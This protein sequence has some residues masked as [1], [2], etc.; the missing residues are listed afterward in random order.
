MTQFVPVEALVPLEVES[1]CNYAYLV[2]QEDSA[3]KLFLAYA[4][5]RDFLSVP[6]T[7]KIVCFSSSSVLE[8][9]KMGMDEY[10]DGFEEDVLI[11]EPGFYQFETHDDGSDSAEEELDIMLLADPVS[12]LEIM[13]ERMDKLPEVYHCADAK[14]ALIT[15]LSA[16][17]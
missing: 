14:I 7:Y 13:Y 1:G 5:K 12:V 8:V 6:L 9:H 10:L 11:P 15:A 17:S 3:D 16:L 4:A 2:M